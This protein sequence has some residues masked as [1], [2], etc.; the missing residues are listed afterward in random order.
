MT[1]TNTHTKSHKLNAPLDIE[2]R[3][4]CNKSRETCL[5]EIRVKYASHTAFYFRLPQGTYIVVKCL[6]SIVWHYATPCKNFS[7]WSDSSKVPHVIIFFNFTT[8]TLVMVINVGLTTC[9]FVMTMSWRMP[10]WVQMVNIVMLVSCYSL[11]LQ[12]TRD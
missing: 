1:C 9:F 12:L 11:N 4:Y 7:F 8:S 3:N 2:I 5:T 10:V 6:V